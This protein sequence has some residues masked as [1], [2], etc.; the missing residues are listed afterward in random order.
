L[1][2]L[3]Y[4]L[5]LERLRPYFWTEV[6][7]FSHVAGALVLSG[8]LLGH[9]GPLIAALAP[10][11]RSTYFAFLFHLLVLDVVKVPLHALIDVVG[12][13]PS[14]VL[15]ASVLLAAATFAGSVAL[16]RAIARTRALAW[17]VP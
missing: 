3:A 1:T 15:G 16:G 2:E 10:L 5:L 17:L 13:G 11:G 9:R 4:A 7:P 8:F 14:F 6:R 12:L